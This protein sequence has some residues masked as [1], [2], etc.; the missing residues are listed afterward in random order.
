[1][2]KCVFAR[3]RG[4]QYTEFPQPLGDKMRGSSVIG[5]VLFP[6]PLR[7]NQL[8]Q[9][10]APHY[11]PLGHCGHGDHWLWCGRA[12][13]WGQRADHQP[14][15]EVD[16]RKRASAQAGKN[17]PLKSSSG[18]FAFAQDLVERVLDHS[19]REARD[20]EDRTVSIRKS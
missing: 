18:F 3:I 11:Q 9:V 20:L 17:R 4:G 19:R 2:S 7:S 8:H 16:V 6:L 10:T 15:A 14:G 12:I 13:V 5:R 1:M